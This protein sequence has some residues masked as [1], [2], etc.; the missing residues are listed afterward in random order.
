M[1]G[2][3]QIEDGE[4]KRTLQSLSLGKQRVLRKERREGED[5]KEISEDT[6]F[7]FNAGFRHRLTRI[8][9]NTIQLKET[10]AEVNKTNE[11][12]LR[13]RQHQVDAALVRIMKSRKTLAHSLLMTE[14]VNQ[15]RFLA[16]ASQIKK[17]IA[18]LIEREYMRRDDESTDV[19]HYVA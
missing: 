6:V 9:I 1:K 13:D 7:H 14:V 2:A 12:V 4:L 17:R 10:V 5:G 11:A 19:Y 8:R 15:L 16:D 18:S 3:T